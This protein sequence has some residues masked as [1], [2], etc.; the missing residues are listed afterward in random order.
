MIRR[1]P[2]DDECQFAL[3]NPK[4]VMAVRDFRSVVVAHADAAI[5][6]TL[7]LM[8]RLKGFAAFALA[9]MESVELIF[10]H[11]WP[12][13]LLLDTRLARQADFGFVREAATS[14]VFRRVLIIAITGVHRER[15]VAEIRELGFDGLCSRPLQLSRLVHMLDEHFAPLPV[16]EP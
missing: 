1:A 6:E 5:G 4:Q 9:D 7:A 11:W 14:P 10:G 16:E 15:S 3:W 8:L 2:H 12:R 13:A